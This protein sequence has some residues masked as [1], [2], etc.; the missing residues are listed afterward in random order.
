MGRRRAPPVLG[1]LVG[2]SAVS[3]ERAKALWTQKSK[4]SSVSLLSR[5]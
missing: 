4:T 2:T 1:W 3:G 5:R